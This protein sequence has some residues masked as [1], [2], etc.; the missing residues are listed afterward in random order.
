MR[1]V[2]FQLDAAQIMPYYVGVDTNL[3][4]VFSYVGNGVVT[5]D[6]TFDIVNS[7]GPSAPT[8]GQKFAD[9]IRMP[10]FI[11]APVFINKGTKLYLCAQGAWSVQ[12]IFEDIAI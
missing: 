1:T 12:L 2:V 6:P 9:I 3:M 11:I 7:L 4:N 8:G 5:T 10:D